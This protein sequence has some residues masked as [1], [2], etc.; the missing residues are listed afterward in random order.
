MKNCSLFWLNYILIISFFI[1]CKTGPDARQELDKIENETEILPP[2]ELYGALFYDVQTRG[3]F[4]DSKTFVDAKPQYDVG[5]IRQR[6]NMLEDTS[7]QGITEFVGQHFELPESDLE[8]K[9]DS[10]SINLHITK[11]WSE[12]KRPAD[13]VRSGTLIP[14]PNPYLVPGGRFREIYY[15]DSYFTMLGLQEDGEIESIHNMVDN[16]A[17]LI[18]EYGFIP[19]GNRTYYLGRSQP[20]FFA[21]M[22]KLLAESKGDKILAKY[23]PELEIEYDFWMNGGNNLRPGEA[24]RRVVRMKE[25]ELLNRYWDDHNTPRPESYIE[26]VQ[27]ARKA[28]SENSAL[29]KE[30]VYRNLRAGAES[31]WDFSSRWL[32]RGTNGNFELSTIHT[33]DILPVDLNSLLYNL[34][35]TISKAARITGNKEKSNNFQ[36]KA[37]ARKQA[38]LKYF[39]NE[40]AGFFMDYNFK[41][42]SVSEQL[43]LAGVYPLFFEIG[44]EDQATK[45]ASKIEEVFLKPGG[46]VST[47]YNTGQQ[48]DAPNGWA[49]LQWISI[50]ALKN[51]GHHKLAEDIKSRWLNL[52]R[53]VYN[54]TYK[55]LEKY[56]VEDL[57]KESGGGE[58]PT[59]DGFGWTNGVYQRLSAEK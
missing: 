48:W 5:L 17:Y 1:S 38:I 11:L 47:P 54:R 7:K 31:G 52:N 12:L 10:S 8:F 24:N 6:Y 56:N 58:Y 53:E 22:V 32:T 39:W 34:E 27:T 26:D 9:L 50:Q 20:P 23:L 55:M 57:T 46:V 16:F 15:W 36:Q 45:L 49:P 59:Q 28:V 30:E 13:E 4:P 29:T 41:K 35:L 43:S 18:N 37:Q 14:L 25:G 44:S 42:G 51:Y 3:I 2:A 33:T 19:N 40:K 21:M